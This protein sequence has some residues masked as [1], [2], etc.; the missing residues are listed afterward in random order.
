MKADDALLQFFE[1]SDVMKALEY[2]VLELLFEALLFVKLLS[3]VSY[4]ISETLLT[5]SQIIDD[6]GKVRVDSVEM[7]ELL[8]HLVGLLVELLNFDLSGSDFTFQ[9]LNLV[10]EDEFEFFKFLSFLLE[11]IDSLIFVLNG[12]FTLLNF[13]SLRKDLL[14]ERV[15]CLNEFVKFLLLLTDLFDG[16]LFCVFGALI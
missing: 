6:Q 1:I 2:I 7:L 8:S 4:L 11:I 5:H 3:K 9:L 16:L 10:I 13:T 12:G 14:S 15:S